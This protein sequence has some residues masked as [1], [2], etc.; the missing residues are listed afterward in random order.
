VGAAAFALV[1]G[2]VCV[3]LG[4]WQLSRYEAKDARATAI[5]ANY[6]RAPV[7]LSTVLPRIDTAL[8]ETQVWTRVSAVGR[9]AADQ[10]LMVR[11]RT[12]AGVLGYEVLVPLLVDGAG[13]LLV[14][15][16]WVAS[17]ATAADLPAVPSAPTGE[18]LVTG[19]LKPGEEV[20]ST[21]LPA[22]QLGSINLD[23]AWAQLQGRLPGPAGRGSYSAYLVLDA[24][25]VAGGHVPARP[26]P[27]DP[28]DPDRGPHFAYAL[29]WWLTSAFG[30]AFVGYLYRSRPDAVAARAARP[31]KP[32]RVRIWDDEDE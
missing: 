12:L 21:G 2:T 29:Q 8:D 26:A 13:T 16:G 30:L 23:Q 17:S 28:P 31:A 19:W 1:F 14:D 32:K 7:P 24:E 3:L 9:Y 5:E 4:R 18:V 27:L 11:A 6:G 25:Q 10:Q 20:R 22:G 15:R